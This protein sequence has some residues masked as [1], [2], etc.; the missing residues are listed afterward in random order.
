MSHE[1]PGRE[2]T[3]VK[4]PSYLSGLA[5]F[6][7]S[8]THVSDTLQGLWAPCCLHTHRPLLEETAV[9]VLTAVRGAREPQSLVPVGMGG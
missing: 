3:G 8:P 5:V 6:L 4:V 7:P 2:S 1:W 9:L